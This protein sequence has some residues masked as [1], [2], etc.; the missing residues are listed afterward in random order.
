MTPQCCLA[1]RLL[2]VWSH[3]RTADLI[4]TGAGLGKT[5]TVAEVEQ[6]PRFI[7]VVLSDDLQ[8]TSLVLGFRIPGVPTQ[9]QH[10]IRT[11]DQPSLSLCIPS[12]IANS[13][14][15]PQPHTPAPHLPKQLSFALN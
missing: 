6:V 12:L 4:D 3:R 11:R 5:K 1:R 7:E 13:P 2:Q 14:V 15:P 9:Q 8:L 10:L